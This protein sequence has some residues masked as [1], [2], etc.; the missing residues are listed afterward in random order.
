[1]SVRCG[2]PPSGGPSRG[3]KPCPSLICAHPP[4]PSEGSC[5]LPAVTAPLQAPSLGLALAEPLP[6][7]CFYFK[8]TSLSSNQQN[9]H[10]LEAA[11]PTGQKIPV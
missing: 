5:S 1:M 3:L 2:A 7:R 6:S 11:S 9:Q 4:L 10:G 8:Q